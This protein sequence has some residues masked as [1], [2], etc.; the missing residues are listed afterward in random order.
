[1]AFKGYLKLYK[2]KL[3]KGY[4]CTTK[5]NK[6]LLF[7]F[8]KIHTETTDHTKI[9]KSFNIKSS[10]D[11]NNALVKIDNNAVNK[12]SIYSNIIVLIDK[13]K[14]KYIKQKNKNKNSNYQII[15]YNNYTK[16]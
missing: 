9:I 11:S 4:I 14:D 7:T 13:L 3:L 6:I 16:Q 2:I 1:M 12:Y 15:E 10:N 8:L 5:N